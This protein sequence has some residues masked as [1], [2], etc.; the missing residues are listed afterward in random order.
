[1]NRQFIT[2]L[3]SEQRRREQE[4]RR[5][6]ENYELSLKTI[7]NVNVTRQSHVVDMRKQLEKVREKDHITHNQDYERLT[8]SNFRYK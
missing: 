2:F 1:M 4:N 5:K 8:N 7:N 3:N 6:K